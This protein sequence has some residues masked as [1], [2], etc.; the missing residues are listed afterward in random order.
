MEIVH[1]KAAFSV[2]ASCVYIGISRAAL[3][4]LM[5]TGAIRNFHIGRRPLFASVLLSLV[6][7]LLLRRLFHKIVDADGLKR[8][9]LVLGAGKKAAAIAASGGVQSI[10]FEV[11]GFIPS[12]IPGDQTG[13]KM[14]N[15][16]F[17][18]IAPG[19]EDVEE[20]LMEF[21]LD[22]LRKKGV[23]KVITRASPRWGKTMD[24]AQKYD[25]TLKELMW[26]NARLD[27]KSY[28]VG[29]GEIAVSDVTDSDLPEIKEILMSFR[30]NTEDGAQN[31]IDLLGRITERVTSWKI[32][33]EAGKIVGHDHLVQ[34]IRDS[35]KS[36]MNA[37]YATRDDIRDSI[38]NAHVRA[39]TEKGIQYIDNF[40]FGPTEQMDGPYYKYGFEI[41]D[42]YAFERQLV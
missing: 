34:D 13:D 22:T 25:Y 28:Q 4:R 26:K 12:R 29:A 16:E 32:V 42:L 10:G 2:N 20:R 7:V 1:E 23:S 30:E 9:I 31:Q 18:L 41:A 21:A 8:K 3:N 17:P 19:N 36:R 5:D 11:V 37:I 38:M 14:A 33:L 35:R 39:A 15:L 24:L 6:C 40:F 27:V